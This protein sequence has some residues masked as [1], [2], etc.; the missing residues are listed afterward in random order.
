MEASMHGD[1]SRTKP[2]SRRQLLQA[3]AAAGITGPA[4]IDLIAQARSS[5]SSENLRQASAILGETFTADRLP[6][7]QAALQRNLDQ[8]QIVRDLEIDD[9]VEPAP[10]F[11]PRRR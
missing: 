1:R 6:V 9:S 2:L 3:L 8:F 7:I 11:D 5:V 10:A 4:A